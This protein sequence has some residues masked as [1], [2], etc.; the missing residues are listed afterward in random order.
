MKKGELTAARNAAPYKYVVVC[1]YARHESHTH[2][3]TT[4]LLRELDDE[5]GSIHCGAAH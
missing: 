1:A 3:H 4:F 5:N 2:T